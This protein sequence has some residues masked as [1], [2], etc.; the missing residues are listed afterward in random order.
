[1]KSWNYEPAKDFE[2]PPVER[3]RSLKRESG[4]WSTAGHL[5]WHAL[6]RA[7]V[8]VYHRLTVEGREHLPPA[9]PFVLIANH[10]SH[11]D[12]MVLASVLSFRW[13]DRVFPVAAGDIFF[14]SPVRSLFSAQMINAL[15]M[16]RKR[17]GPHALAELKDRLIS[18]PCAYLLFPEGTRSRDGSLQRFKAGLGM[19]VAGTSV[20]VVPCSI[21]GAARAWPA[22]SC[23]PRPRRLQL[24][25]GPP[26]NF[27][28]ISNTRAGW[29][30]VA[31]EAED[32][33]RRL[34]P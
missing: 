23:W 29:E 4:M 34:P 32:A 24:K 11:L 14:E 33:V 27:L 22:G 26:L 28:D 3:A 21:A 10:T 16:W 17:C 18:E 9:P 12:S 2:L 30:Q 8:T 15:P 13:C 5:V 7:Y 19:I 25:I 20:P 6:V 31:R 1:V